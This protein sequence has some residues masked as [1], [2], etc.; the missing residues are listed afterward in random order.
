[1]I[2][3]E[4]MASV[5]RTDLIIRYDEDYYLEVKTD[6][7][8]SIFTLIGNS[9]TNPQDYLFKNSIWG[10][11]ECHRI[12]IKEFYRI[13]CAQT[14]IQYIDMLLEKEISFE[15][16]EDEVKDLAA[17]LRWEPSI[18]EVFKNIFDYKVSLEIIN[19]Y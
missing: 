5:L 11:E 18:I 10:A 16:I 15:D 19:S 3:D 8:S 2:R 14:L 17:E 7:I 4:V 13:T 6:G 12:T 9:L 1:M